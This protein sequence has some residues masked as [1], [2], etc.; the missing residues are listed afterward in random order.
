MIQIRNITKSYDRIVLNHISYDFEDGKFYLIHSVSGGGKSTLLNILGGLET[1]YSGCYYLDGRKMDNSSSSIEALRSKIGYIFQE[2]LL[3][4]HLNVLEN[5]KFI[6]NDEKEIQSLA[7]KM[8]VDHLLLNMPEEMSNGERQRIAVI[9]AL[10]HHPTIL[11][12]D[13]PTSAL[14]YER[15]K[16]IERVFYT[17]RE[18]GITLIVCTHDQE[19]AKEADFRMNLDYGVIEQPV[20]LDIKN[21]QENKEVKNKSKTQS[22]MKIDV[23]YSKARARKAKTGTVIMYT[24]IF[25]SLFLAVMMKFNFSDAMKKAYVSKYP[26]HIGNTSLSDDEIQK[27]F[28]EG[29]YVYEDYHF[30]DHDFDVFG[31]FSMKDSSVSIPNAIKTG[32]FPKKDNE[33]LVNTKYAVQK[34]KLNDVEQ[35]VGKTISVKGNAFVV[36]GVLTDDETITYKIKESGQYLTEMDD[37]KA[38]VLM[39]YESIKKISHIKE[40]QNRFVAVPEAFK[41][42]SLLEEINGYWYAYIQ[43]VISGFQMF[44]DIFLIAA[45]VISIIMFLFLMNLIRVDIMNRRREIGYMR[46]FSIRKKRIQRIIYFDYIQKIVSSLLFANI[47]IS[48]ASIFLYMKYSIFLILFPVQWI[49]VHLILLLYIYGLTTAAMRK[50]LHMPIIKL[51]KNS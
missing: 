36:S 49:A 16:E 45:A 34:M 43:D 6:R 1:E 21:G 18:M 29:S 28:P 4:S 9:R 14:D 7:K 39:P 38:N 15:S 42:P 24:I 8:E 47:L 12:A 19:F 50:T 27:E 37:Q 32:S 25:C 44:V 46:L 41:E 20:L 3:F 26:V 5:L 33:V 51:I 31:V 35:A 10:L 11:L 2:S 17:L 40:T 22:T 48:I 30:T 23:N 13:E